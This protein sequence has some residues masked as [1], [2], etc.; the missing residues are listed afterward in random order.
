VRS[1]SF[2]VASSNPDTSVGNSSAA[3]TP[4]SSSRA[5]R[6]SR[7]WYS[8]RSASRSNVYADSL[9]ASIVVSPLNTSS[10]HPAT[11]IGSNVGFGK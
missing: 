9:A 10:R 6:A 8:G 11:A 5:K 1:T 2:A 7:C 4:C 3:S